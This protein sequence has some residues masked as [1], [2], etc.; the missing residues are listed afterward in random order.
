MI[1][2]GLLFALVAGAGLLWGIRTDDALLRDTGLVALL[3]NGYTRY[4]EFFW[5]GMNKGLFFL[6]LAVSFFII[7]RWLGKGGKTVPFFRAKAKV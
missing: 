2:Y 4:F 3:L 1:G 6:V 7:G 5:D